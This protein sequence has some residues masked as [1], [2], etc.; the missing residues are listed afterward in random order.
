MRFCFLAPIVAAAALASSA[1]AAITDGLVHHWNFDEGPDW[2]DSPF[3]TACTNTVAEDSVG[4]ANATLQNMGS[5]NWVSG[6]QFTALEFDGVNE[7]LLV[8]TN[9]ANTLGGTASLSFWL[10]TT[11]TGAVSAATAPG[12]AGAA[13]SGGLQWGWLD[14]AG[15]IGLSMDNLLVSHSSDPVNDGRWH[16]LVLTRDSATGAGQV[17]VDGTLSGSAIGPTGARSSAFSSLARIENGGS[18]NYFKGRLD[19]VHVFNRVLGTAEVAMLRTNHA[20]KI[21]DTTTEG[22]NS[23]SF[24]TTSI[25]AKAYDVERDPLTVWGWTPPAHGSVTPN[26]DGSFTYTANGGF[27]GGDS[28]AVVV[29]DGSGGFHR[30]NMKVTVMH[31]PPGGGGVPVTQFTGFA[32]LQ[33]NGT[34]VSYNG[35]RIP[36]AADWNAD[37]KLDLLIGAG[38]YVWLHTNIG[39]ETTP[40]FSTGV[41]IKAA[42]TDI[43]AG[44]SSSPIAFA[45]VTGDGAL[46]LLLADSA[47]RLRLYRN[48]AAAGL[49]PV[50]A[51]YVTLK[52]PRG[53]DF[54]L[55]DRRFD[56]GDWDGD[57]KID[58]VTGSFSG[59]MQLFLNVGTLAEARFDTGTTLLSDSYNIYPRLYDLNGN[60]RVDFLRGINWGS[61]LYWR[62]APALGLGNSMTLTLTDSN[63]VSPD[64]HALTDGAIVDFADFNR[65][66]T[67]DLIIGGHASD[68]LF[69]AYGLR[70]TIAQSLAE[71]EAIYDANPT[72]VGVA[73]SAN[74]NALLNVV[75]NANWNLISYLQSG[76]L[77]TREA[78]FTAL[79]NHI[80]KYWFL[81]YQTLD[82]AKF[83]HVPSIVLQNWVMLQYTLADTPTLR[84]NIAG[85]MGLTGV[86]RT[87]YLENGL[88]LGDNAKSIPAAYGTL[89]DFRRRHPREL[90]PDAMMSLDQLY[91]DSRGGFVWTP[92]SAKNTFGDWAVGLANEW[93]GDLTAPIEKVLGSGA[94]SGDYFTFV[95]GHEV[96]HSLDGYVNSRRNLDL[97]RRWGLTLCTAAGPDIIPRTNGWWDWTATQTNFQAKGY[98]NGNSSTWNTAWSN[99]WA[100]GAGAPFRNLSFMRGGID[101]FMG[102]PQESLATQANHYWANAPGRL[103]GAVDRFRRATGPGLGPLRANINEVVTFIDYQSA[104]MNRVNLIETKTQSSPQQVN[105][106]DHYA[107]IERDDRGYIIRIT[108]DGQ[109]YDFTVDTDGVVR[110]VSCSITF[111]NPDAMIAAPN[112]AQ[113]VDVTGNDSRLDGNVVEVESFTQP[114]HGTVTNG[115]GLLWYV[116]TPGYSGMDSFTYQ[117]GSSTTTVLMTLPGANQSAWTG[118]GTEGLW[119]QAANWY[120]AVPTNGQALLFL[121]ARQLKNTNNL[122]TTAGPVSFLNGGFTLGGNG[123]TLK[124]G[125]LNVAGDNTWAISSTLANA[126]SFVSSN[127]TLTI[128]APV[129][130][131]GYALTVDGPANVTLSGPVAGGGGV[132]KIGVGTLRLS[133]GNSYSGVTTVNAGK[134]LATGGGWYSPRSIG[135]GALTINSGATAEFT[136]SHGFGGD[137]Y[138]RSA[139][140]N[141][142]TLQLDGDNYVSGLT[143]TGGSVLSSGGYLALLNNTYTINASVTPSI[144]SAITLTLQGSPTFNVANGPAAVDL[145][146]SGNMSSSAA[147]TLTKTGAGL[148]QYTGTGAANSTVVSAGTLQLDGAL[149]TNTVT[150]RNTATLAGVGVISGPLTVQSGGTLAPGDNGVGTLTTGPE[151]WNGGGIYLCDLN[152]TTLNG[153]DQLNISGSLNLLATAANRFTIQLVS[154]T[155]ANTPGLLAD[156]NRAVPCAWTVATAADAS[157]F[158]PVKFTINTTS[159]INDFTG[160]AFAIALRGNALVL[161]YH[162]PPSITLTAPTSGAEVFS[163]QLTGATGQHYRVEYQPTLPP[164]GP[165]QVLTD[166]ASLA[167]SPLTVF[168]TATSTQRFYRALSVP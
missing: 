133:S 163:L 88:A 99:Y 166:I 9:L 149:G 39:T 93:A 89:R 63:N 3:R 5:S 96:T 131:A 19:Q 121:G 61:I 25:F 138:G 151:T 47:G 159:F 65:D 56:L 91:G 152:S 70:K 153:C 17:F 134:L 117:A 115:N 112:I 32:A 38:G 11:Q 6:R 143:L 106:F 62:D 107:E 52:N 140:V 45:D 124:G 128:S 37:G 82:T 158:D 51:A 101:W 34:N 22:V 168:D 36:R 139:T 15:R 59:A 142:G 161:Q 78:L 21:W 31:E 77:G 136:Q 132:T 164:V 55:P 114:A 58:L 113:A 41:K 167:V 162:P 54:L 137:N 118:G 141:G 49:A 102:S 16:H 110:D 122:L 35:W 108:V 111:L 75:N 116:P 28:F 119:S 67:P 73:L 66:G 42:G 40:T 83:H 71:I 87:I 95:M 44:T 81:K 123:L 130:N 94:A 126:Q 79:T 23:R 109:T 74:S 33:S 80:G 29:A 129:A 145:V 155:P 86:A 120:G 4:G 72:N 60:G 46:D 18:P 43:Y 165:W 1:P 7:H 150:V 144:I 147:N 104:G 53:T 13:G 85:V 57:G 27:L 69:L 98:W 24:V 30:A 48:T 8:A 105:W 84:T 103:I 135:S 157:G 125:L 90:F 68:K 127:G 12:L 148:L 14:T 97:Y 100:V 26:A 156:F 50:L 146:L 10:R 160:G 76:T 20:P 64:L 92:N 2:H 154:L